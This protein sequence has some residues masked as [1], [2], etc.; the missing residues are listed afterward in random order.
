MR[1]RSL[2]DRDIPLVAGWLAEPGTRQWLWFG[3]GVQSLSPASLKM[4]ARR[5]LHVLRLF[6]AD[7]DGP[8][9]GIVALSDVDRAFRTAALW[10]VLGDPAHRGRG[11]TSRAVKSLLTEGFGEGIAAVSAWAVS[12]NAASVRV[13]ERNGFRFIGRQRACHRIDGHARDR[14]LYDLVADEHRG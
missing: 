1:L 5:D 3:P 9:V 10:F 11:L 14:L 2:E 12:G 13:L 6:A 8:P 7:A 4:M